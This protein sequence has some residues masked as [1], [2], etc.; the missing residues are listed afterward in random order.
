MFSECVGKIDGN[1]KRF[2]Q[3]FFF[4]IN[5][6]H[7]MSKC[8]VVSSDFKRVLGLD[9]EFAMFGLDHHQRILI[10]H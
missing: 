4:E 3:F 9:M 10:K 1:E 5:F 8:L 7:R 6:N 2:P